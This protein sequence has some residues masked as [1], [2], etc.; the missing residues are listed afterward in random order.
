MNHRI[1]IWAL[2][3]ATLS[4]PAFA[5]DRD[6]LFWAP[7][8]AGSPEQAAETMAEFGRYLETAAGWAEGTID[9]SYLNNVE[10][11][12][13]RL[14]EDAPGFLVVT[15]PVFL[16]HHR[17]QGWKPLLIL[18][19]DSADA[20]RYSLY[21]PPGS[22][23][24]SLSGAPLVGDSAYDAAFVATAVLRR[25]DAEVPFELQPTDRPLSAVRK[26]SRGERMAVLLDEAQRIALGSLPAGVELSLLAESPW[27]PAGI[28][29]ASPAVA[30]ADAEAVR[31]A[32]E[33]AAEDPA[34]KE[35]L[36]TMKIRRF[37]PPV[38]EALST[39]ARSY[40]AA[41]GESAAGEPTG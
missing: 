28:L 23:L 36:T 21:G 25:E 27:M 22:T 18:V 33:R 6:L 7:Y 13:A 40:D 26:A 3:L 5:A 8:G 20:Q 34:A 37:E 30:P 16:R 32:L 39:L 41:R 1:P 12:V 15:V 38:P 9:T 31:E 17:G 11:G 14:E 19:T 4:G 10:D 29:V 2:A 24:E 35:I